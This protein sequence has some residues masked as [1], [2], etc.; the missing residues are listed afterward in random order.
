MQMSDQGS[1]LTKA[2]LA[3]L[4]D[5]RFFTGMTPLMSQHTLNTSLQ[6]HLAKTTRVLATWRQDFLHQKINHHSSNLHAL[7]FIQHREGR[8]EQTSIDTAVIDFDF[9]AVSVSVGV[10]VSVEIGVTTTVLGLFVALCVFVVR[11]R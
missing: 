6:H 3:S 9:E 2:A 4:T 7:D 1:L 11:L 10:G 8:D 5:V